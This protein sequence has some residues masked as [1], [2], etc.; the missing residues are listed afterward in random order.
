MSTQR[1]TVSLTSRTL[2]GLR[3][4][5]RELNTPI[6]RIVANLI[7][8]HEEQRIAEL[9]RQGYREFSDLNRELAEEFWPMAGETLPDD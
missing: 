7:E 1:I 6:S 2:A 5:S 8:E 3:Q 9:M 4:E